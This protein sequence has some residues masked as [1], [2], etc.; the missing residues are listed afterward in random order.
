MDERSGLET[1]SGWLLPVTSDAVDGPERSAVLAE[2]A[3]GGEDWVPSPDVPYTWQAIDN[4]DGSTTLMLAVYPFFYNPVTTDSE[5]YRHY[6]FTITTTMTALTITHLSTGQPVYEPG[7]PVGVDLQVQNDDP[8][9]DVVV[10][11]EIQDPAGG[12]VS[13]LLLR[14]LHG[15]GGPI[16]FAPAWDSTGTP[17]GDYRVVVTLRDAEGGTLDQDEVDFRLGAVEGEAALTVDPD[18][19]A[20]GPHFDI[21]LAFSNTGSVPITG[22][23]VVVLPGATATFPTTWDATGLPEQD[24]RVQGQ[25]KYDGRATPMAVVDLA[26]SNKVYLPAVLR[27]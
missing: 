13:G 3:E 15:L 21:E 1:H 11:A 24:Y 19:F 17:A 6:G 10:E 4:P 26:S 23:A 25:V 8:A 7:E 2:T 9:L 12:V 16:T 22:T 18:T 14:T 20:A 5:Y 27:Q